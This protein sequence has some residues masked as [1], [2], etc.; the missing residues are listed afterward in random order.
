[1]AHKKQHQEIVR[2]FFEGRKR[3]ISNFATDGVRL[4]VH[5]N[6][7]AEKRDAGLY[8]TDAGWQTQLTKNMLNEVM[9]QGFGAYGLEGGL[10]WQ[11]KGWWVSPFD[12][13]SGLPVTEL[14]TKWPG[15]AILKP[16]R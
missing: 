3:S 6:L 8:I 7:V 1:M 16:R 9:Y 15:E 12:P 11:A 10:I 5:G 2:A 4:F 14:K 13:V